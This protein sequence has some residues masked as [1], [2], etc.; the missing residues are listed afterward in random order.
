MSPNLNIL[1]T[2]SQKQYSTKYRN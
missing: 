2:S 1:S